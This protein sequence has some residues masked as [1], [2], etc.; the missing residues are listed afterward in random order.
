MPVIIGIVVLLVVAF[1]AFIA[2][3]ANTFRIQRQ[4]QIN[5]APDVVF[6]LI[7]DFHN[8][9]RWSAW[10]TVDPNLQRS[11]SGAAAG[12]GAV[13]DW[14]GNSKAGVGRMTLLESTPGRQVKIK[15]EFIKPFTATHQVTFELVP[16]DG[17]TQV[18]WIIAG[19]KDFRDKMMHALMDM[20]KLIGKDFE[21]GLANMDQVACMQP[22]AGG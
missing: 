20:D 9:T 3:R 7:N 5:A 13:Y 6:G 12:P 17:G 16:V 19:E 4:R 10:E 11:Y 2:T 1:I 21:Q 18:S 15:L 22:A 14:S 8:W